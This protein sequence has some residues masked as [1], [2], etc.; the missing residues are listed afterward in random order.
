MKLKHIIDNKAYAVLSNY[1]KT[2][3]EIIRK[4]NALSLNKYNVSSTKF[5]LIKN[6]CKRKKRLKFYIEKKI[7]RIRTNC[8]QSDVIRLEIALSSIGKKYK[9][10]KVMTGRPYSLS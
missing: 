2:T 6:T 4:E 7:K 10:S 9:K 3:N 1:I 5:M 8:C